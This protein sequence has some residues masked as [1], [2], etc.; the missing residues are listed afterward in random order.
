LQ[1]SDIVQAANGGD[2]FSGMMLE[3]TGSYVGTAIANVINLLNIEK[4]VV[5]GEVMETGGIVLDA[6]SKS[7]K[8]LSF[9]PSFE[10][11]RIVAGE[12][13]EWAT[14][15]GAAL[16]SAEANQQKIN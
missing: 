8:E 3:R 10:T 5:G 13:G 15:I 7:A 11:T 16:L 6:I 1:I 2:G 9:K 12:L 4:I 14:A